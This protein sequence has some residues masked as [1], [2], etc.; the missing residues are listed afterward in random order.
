[1]GKLFTFN[2]DKSEAKKLGM[3]ILKGVG[4]VVLGAT[5]VVQGIAESATAHHSIR[6][7]ET[8][9][10]ELELAVEIADL[11]QK[12]AKVPSSV[13]TPTPAPAPEP[14]PVEPPCDA[15]KDDGTEDKQ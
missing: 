15:D 6:D 14:A 7:L 3:N 12:L 13:P 9:K 1:M 4:N 2:I 11:K 8:Q 5:S 10:R